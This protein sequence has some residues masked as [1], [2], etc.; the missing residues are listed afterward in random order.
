MALCALLA[1]CSRG[2]SRPPPRPAS[3]SP[4]AAYTFADV[5]V[6]IYGSHFDPVA[7]QRV[8]SGG[9]VDVDSSFRAF[10]GTV[11]LQDV[12]WQ[13][14]DR[15]TATVPA[16]LS[17]GPF[18]LRVA[19]PT[20]EGTASAVFAASMRRPASIAPA[21]S[22]PARVE[23]GTQAEVDLLLT[24]GGETTVAQ[25]S[26]QLTADPGV[27][28]VAVPKMNGN[29]KP[30]ETVHLVALVAGSSIG[31][32]TLT[33]NATGVDGFDGD[34]V[35]AVASTAVQIVAPAAL[36]AATIP[37]PDLV[38]VGQS[39]DLVATVT[40]QGDVDALGVAL[41]GPVSI[42]GSGGAAIDAMPPPQDIPGGTSRTFHI[43]AH[44]TAAGAVFFAC[45]V[46]GAD[47]ITA[48]PVQVQ[49]SWDIVFV[50]A[51]AQLSARWLT[52]PPFIA[53][54]QTL[55]ATLG[56]TNA[57]EALARD[58]APS[59]NPPSVGANSGSGT[60]TASPAPAPVDVPGGSTAVF[61]WT[62]TAG[63]TPPASLALSAGATGTDANSGVAL[64]A[65]PVTSGAIALQT[66]SSLSATLAAPAAALRGD[67]FTVTLTVVDSGSIGVNGLVPTLTLSGTAAA[68]VSAPTPTTQSLP[69]ASTV[70]FT[71]TGTATS[72]GA[73]AL[74]AEVHGTDAA[75][76][77]ARS[78]TAG[79][80]VAISDAVQ[81]ANAPLGAATTF[82]Y[83]FDFNGR[84]YLGPSSN[85]TGGA[86]MLPDG[87]SPESFTMSFRADRSNGNDNPASTTSF[88][89]L[90]FTNC[91]H[92]TL[93][94]G[95][96]NENG[97]GLFGSGTIA[98]AP[99]LFA[100]GGRVNSAL[101]HVYATSDTGTAPSFS[102]DYVGNQ[103]TSQTRGAS[104]MLVFRDRLYLGFADTGANRPTYL[105][106]RKMPSAPGSTPSGTDVQNLRLDEVSGIG[107]A[108][109]LGRNTAL[110]QLV[111]AQI[112]FN[113]LVYAANNGGIVH[114]NTNDPR[115]PLVNVLPDWT[116]ATPS[117]ASYA[118]KTSITTRKTFDLEPADKAVPQM[119]VLGG[120]LYAARNTTAG[121][122][123]WA[124][125]PGADRV[126]DPQDWSLLA[127][128]GLGDT[129]LSQFDDPQNT[130]IT[131]L[132]ATSSRLYVGYNNAA[133]LVLY[134][135]RVSPPASR[136]DFEGTAGCDASLAPSSCDGLG[137]RG[138]GAGATRIFD[139]RVIASGGKD[140]VYLT[141]GNGSS[142]FRVYRLVQ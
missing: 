52:V 119:A 10:L 67:T 83:V 61:S 1:A 71:W 48:A 73:V 58:V 11:E 88:P 110:T 94:C 116:S 42:T 43:A 103:L 106:I 134:R 2:H 124:C 75:D 18:D 38:S 126:C 82:A 12:R 112:A 76:G 64:T 37:V 26:A 15:L 104:S 80:T 28:V 114:S 121:P 32:A 4:A 142:G 138:L 132:A 86:R 22:A 125:D 72:N 141:A 62:L 122:Q 127:P 89:S 109:L 29:I 69:G 136:A 8:G 59:P 17:G 55:T 87:S 45:P 16:G 130:R 41:V 51:A 49:A 100:A 5:P 135:S 47:A 40:N 129:T 97:R 79:A 131:L 50:Q 6:T 39:L 115:P 33:L 96:D 78:A 90:G 34:P 13:A 139:G 31:P 133:G 27:A 36:T 98:G 25:P 118:A 19:G 53:P 92:D 111:D 20:G 68:T 46:S 85:G 84:V 70:T 66:A 102:Y 60:L 57:G 93:Q 107:S 14:P 54:G 44:A 35:D 120:R 91:A 95:P 113:D 24:N 117:A 101:E 123:L 108:A 23:L 65:A 77:S 3:I 81:L 99:W 140:Y 7:T 30:G 137:G 74:S 128:N 56:V 63:G 21:L 9:A 105:V